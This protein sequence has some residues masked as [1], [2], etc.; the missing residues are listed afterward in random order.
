M[1]NQSVTTE[2][3]TTSWAVVKGFFSREQRLLEHIAQI[4]KSLHQAGW[5]NQQERLGY[6]NLL[7]QYNELYE[8]YQKILGS[9]ESLLKTIGD[10]TSDTPPPSA[11]EELRVIFEKPD[12]TDSVDDLD[13]YVKHEV[14][15]V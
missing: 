3:I 2:Y 13:E 4:E 1:Q 6:T 7:S 12:H 10:K 14:N 8:G 15:S 11:Y 9:Y 5:Q